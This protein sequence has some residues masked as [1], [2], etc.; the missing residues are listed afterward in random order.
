[1]P[2]RD[3]L[4]AILEGY[5]QARQREA[6]PGRFRAVFDR[7]AGKVAALSAVKARP[8]IKV[9]AGF[10]VGNWARSPWVCLMDERGSSSPQEGVFIS[11]KFR[12]DMAGFYVSLNQGHAR[13]IATRGRKAARDLWRQRS[14]E[15][16]MLAAG[17]PESGF[18]LDDDL[19]LKLDDANAA[20][21][22]R[23]SSV[24]WRYH[25]ATNLPD[26]GGLDREIA[27]LIQV[28]TAWLDRQARKSE[29]FD[30]TA[31]AAM[32]Q[33]FLAL[34]SGFLSFAEPGSVYPIE[35]RDYKDEL[36]AAFR[37]EIAPLLARLP[38]TPEQAK[39]ALAALSEFLTRRKLGQAQI[40]QNLVNWRMTEHLRSLDGEEALQAARLY[41]DLLHGEADTPDRVEAFSSGYVPILGR[42]MKSGLQGVTRSLPTLLLM[43]Q[44]PEREI[45][46]RTT[47][48]DAAA[49]QLLGHRLLSAD[50]LTAGDYL[51]CR[52][53]AQGIRRVLEDWGWQPKD[54]IDVQSF[55]WVSDPTSYGTIEPKAD[56]SAFRDALDPQST[57]RIYK[58][59]PGEQARFWN[60]CRAGGFICVGWDDVGDLR[61]F[62]AEDEESFTEAF[63]EAYAERYIGSSGK[64]AVGTRK[65]RELWTLRKIEAG[66][67]ILANRGVSELLAIGEV[68][69]P[70]Y[71]FDE[72]RPE[73]K[74][75]LR[76]RWNEALGRDLTGLPDPGTRARWMNSTI[77]PVERDLY[78]AIFE[79]RPIPPA[80]S[81]DSV[82]D[83]YAGPAFDTIVTAIRKSGMRLSQ[84]LVRR[85][86]TAV[87]ARG[88]VI[89]AG[90]SGTGKTWLA[91]TYADAVGA[92][93]LMVRV[94]PNWNSNEDLLGFVS[95][96]NGEYQHTRFSQF[97][98][99]ADKAFRQAPN[100]ET[101]RPFHVL[102][103]EMNLAR[104]EHYFADFLSALEQRNRHGE[105]AVILGA[106]NV[107]IHRNLVFAGT[108]N[109]DE[110]THGFAH[111]VYDRAQLIEV[112]LDAASFQAHIAT[113]PYADDL[114]RVRIAVAQVAPIAF[115]TADDICDY[116]TIA[117]GIDPG[118]QGA[119][120]E[121]M[122]QKVLPRIR[123]IDQAVGD[124]LAEIIKITE[125]RYPLS[126]A[127]AKRMLEGFRLGV[128]SFF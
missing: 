121:T 11:L 110:T 101:A 77:V 16:R 108:V 117:A 116:V 31:L 28:Y 64:L 10:G 75:L 47:L 80:G 112:E 30:E 56:D 89:L 15:I 62:T 52:E 43:L 126:H 124:A 98:I 74:H 24:A 17:L 6:F 5:V 48:F 70:G 63:R 44:D 61:T 7:L 69:E 26:D 107:V 37:T 3:E 96:L 49:Q 57:R 71:E 58:I 14:T 1:M 8:D 32:K 53:F 50:P 87:K 67:I 4:D 125:G 60:E 39:A 19:D 92:R 73:F 103:D 12:Q 38:E 120:D 109:M 20:A 40:V 22:F 72:G 21:D 34:M 127:K 81:D 55:L 106:E 25:D 94:A 51:A 99:E 100:A 111:K 114:E 35:E 104:V 45:F 95:P 93:F 78:A 102:L 86:H 113:Q 36:A 76:V 97:L 2:I 23:A 123:G 41:A 119:F 13:D 91:E 85:Y 46:V 54:M 42:H 90:V 105:A 128:A 29:P 84:R 82:S 79:G 65:A 83:I 66:D 122:L 118:W 33:R 59:A 18:R 88:F 27:A 115:R 68:I 9:R